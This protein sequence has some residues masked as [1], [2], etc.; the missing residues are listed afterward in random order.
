VSGAES[1]DVRELPEPPPPPAGGS[2]LSG[3]VTLDPNQL[4]GDEDD[5]ALVN[6]R[7]ALLD[8]D[9]N[10][11]AFTFTDSQGVYRFEN[12]EAGTYQIKSDFE[13][14]GFFYVDETNQ[15]VDPSLADGRDYVGTVNGVANGDNGTDDGDVDMLRF[16]LLDDDDEGINYNFSSIRAN[17]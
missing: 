15:Q 11:I 7:I 4:P 3:K 2:S 17:G 14:G 13:A 9:F 16:I 8:A 5:I 1:W 10:E 6:V 12:L